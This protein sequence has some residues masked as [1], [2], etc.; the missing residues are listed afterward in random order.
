MD[1]AF[2][3]LTCFFPG[4]HHL[5]LLRTPDSGRKLLQGPENSRTPLTARCEPSSTVQAPGLLEE[6]T[7][8]L[9]AVHHDAL[10]LWGRHGTCVPILLP[11]LEPQY[12]APEYLPSCS[13]EKLCHS[14]YLS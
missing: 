2:P 4:G 1:L 5:T 7:E 14:F 8:L 9:P 11:E 10:L 12:I 6:D 3:F 13:W